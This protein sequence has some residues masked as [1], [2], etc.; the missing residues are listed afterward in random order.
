M[1]LPSSFPC[2]SESL[3]LLYAS[4]AEQTKIKE[5][6][7]ELSALFEEF[8]GNIF[9]GPPSDE[10][11]QELLQQYLPSEAREYQETGDVVKLISAVFLD[12][13]EQA[14]FEQHGHKRSWESSEEEW[15]PET[16][17][18]PLYPNEDE[19][20]HAEKRRSKTCVPK[21]RKVESGL[22]PAYASL[23]DPNLIPL[24]QDVCRN[25]GT[26]WQMPFTERMLYSDHI[27]NP[28][29]RFPDKLMRQRCNN[30][31]S[32]QRRRRK[33]TLMMW[34]IAKLIPVP[35]NVDQ[36]Q[37][38]GCLE[39]LLL[40]VFFWIVEVQGALSSD[41]NYQGYLP[42]NK[43]TMDNVFGK[44]N[45]HHQSINPASAGSTDSEKIFLSEHLPVGLYSYLGIQK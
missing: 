21:K 38:I 40:T 43:L 4:D 17:L 32:E 30:R 25:K 34:L 10:S 5:E 39:S 9:D 1:A 15:P 2:A 24:L 44:S 27:R 33:I 8:S 23:N 12:E 28:N 7:L 36:M 3:D 31:E 6:P 18:V 35:S 22:P 20:Q 19:A 45:Y 11:V 13:G 14:H 37:R 41:L 42:C 26:V 29:N 16:K